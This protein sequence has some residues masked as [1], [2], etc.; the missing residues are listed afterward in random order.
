MDDV[1]REITHDYKIAGIRIQHNL[2]MNSISM[3]CD[4]LWLEYLV[5]I[6]NSEAFLKNRHFSD[7]IY[8]LNGVFVKSAEDILKIAA[9]PVSDRSSL[10]LNIIG[11]ANDP[12][13]Q[14]CLQVCYLEI[15]GTGVHTL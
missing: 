1:F 13:F 14:N 10:F 2:P 9:E 3:T 4:P 7:L 12:D 6:V 5:L 8:T 11:S 15:G